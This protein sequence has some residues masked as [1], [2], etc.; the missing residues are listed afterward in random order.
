MSGHQAEHQAA[1]VAAPSGGLMSRVMARLADL[2]NLPG[3][4]RRNPVRTAVAVGVVL[5][6]A[7][8][9]VVVIP[10][11]VLPTA[12]FTTATLEQALQALDAGDEETAR[13]IAMDVRNN[14]KLTY[15]Q[16]G[17]P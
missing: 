12:V 17:G 7:V 15:A 10:S 2:R 8:A 6:I 4:M 9:S 3:W 16:L 5:A 1:P 14:P 11:S 13:R